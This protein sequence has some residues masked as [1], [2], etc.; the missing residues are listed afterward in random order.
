MKHI[1][2]VL[3]FFILLII[4]CSNT[5]VKQSYYKSAP[6]QYK[7]SSSHYQRKTIT[8]IKRGDKV[9]VQSYK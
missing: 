2:I 3:L 5:A 9:T 1:K 4:G 8:I 6:S 7:V